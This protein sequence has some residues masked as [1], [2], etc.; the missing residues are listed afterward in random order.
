[1]I[2]IPVYLFALPFSLLLITST[3]LHEVKEYDSFLDH[4]E[5]GVEADRLADQLISSPEGMAKSQAIVEDEVKVWPGV[6]EDK[7]ITLRIPADKSVEVVLGNRTLYS[8]GNFTA[9]AYSVSRI[10]LYQD[11]PVVLRVMVGSD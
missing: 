1:M 3:L 2:D 4:V 6:I 9:D 8:R 10:V 11:R 5:L 7:D